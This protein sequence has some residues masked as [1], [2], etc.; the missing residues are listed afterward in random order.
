MRPCKLVFSI[1]FVQMLLVQAHAQTQIGGSTCT[2]ASLNGVYGITSSGRLVTPSGTIAKIYQGAGTAT[3]DGQSK[4]TFALSINTG[5]GS[6]QQQTYSGTYNIAANCS[7]TLTANVSLGVTALYSVGVWNQGKIFLMSGSD[8]TYTLI[9]NG[10]IQ[11]I[12]PCQ[13]SSLSGSY[14]YQV[15][16]ESFSGTAVTGVLVSTGA[17]QFDGQ[18]NLTGTSSQVVSG[19]LTAVTLTGTYTV[20]SN[21]TGSATYTDST[22]KSYTL[23][24]TVNGPEFVMAGLSSQTIYSGAGHA[25][26]TSA[27]QATSGTCTDASLTGSYGL[28]LGGRQVTSAGV[29][30]SVDEGVGT[31][32]FDGQGG[33]T[34]TVNTNVSG[35]PTQQQSYSGTYSIAS[36]CSGTLTANVSSGVTA[37]YSVGVYNVGRNILM[38]G[39]DGTYAFNANAAQEASACLVSSLS[40]DYA[41]QANGWPFSGAAVAGVVDFSGI[42]HF[43]GQGSFT[44]TSSQIV[45]GALTT[46]TQT[47]TYTVAPGCLGTATYTDS[48]GKSYNLSLSVTVTGSD[49]FFTGLGSAVMFGGSGHVT[50][51]SASQAI[52]NAASFAKGIAA[53][54]SIFAIFGQN[55]ASKPDS[56]GVVPLP[57]TLGATSVTV[58][59]EAAPLFYVSPGQINAQVPW[60]V[61][62]GMATVIVKNGTAVSNAAAINVPAA[63]PGIFTYGNNRAVVQNPDH[64]VNSDA[65]PAKV[66][67]VLVAYFTGGG[68]AQTKSPLATGAANPPAAVPIVQTNYSVTVAGTAATVNYIGLAPYFVGLYQANFHVPQVAA[69]NRLLVIT[70]GGTASN[71]ALVTIK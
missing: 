12:S 35:G 43:D 46:V 45:S 37:L 16:G 22:G 19:A 64:S 27:G 59:G 58:N 67:D 21:C 24:L 1:L 4:V 10:T 28:Q 23:A 15:N 56:A 36:N 17:F 11:T 9:A 5:S 50:F 40:G 7:G 29:F 32:N 69:G 26:F 2:N 41:Y 51:V 48:L 38:S 34:F 61:Q 54:G 71:A 39:S 42:F 60:D 47:G 55:L 68:A 53:P 14:P 6:T 30:S 13:V 20:S 66:G 63:A 33:V 25:A 44:G 65:A 57:D 3:F 52:T 70:I 8:G 18:G 62:P 31:A 49:L